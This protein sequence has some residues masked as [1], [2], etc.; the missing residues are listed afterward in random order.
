MSINT[1]AI[2]LKFQFP[3]HQGFDIQAFQEMK[4][5]RIRAFFTHGVST[6]FFHKA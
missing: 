2:L 5:K 1:K 3:S 4:I 6:E